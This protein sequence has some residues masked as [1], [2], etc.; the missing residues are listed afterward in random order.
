MQKHKIDL[1][2][3]V[4]APQIDFM[5]IFEMMT[6][7]L[8][9]NFLTIMFVYGAIQFTKD[10]KRGDFSWYHWGLMGFPLAMGLLGLISAGYSPTWLGAVA[11]Q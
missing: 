1:V 8:M 11:A 6:A 2:Y 4:A 9:A 7:V 10:E 3:R 5:T